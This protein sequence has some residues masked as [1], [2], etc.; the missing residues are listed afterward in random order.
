MFAHFAK[1][2]NFHNLSKIIF[3]STLLMLF[4][5]MNSGLAQNRPPNNTSKK[6]YAIVIGISRYADQGIEPLQFAHRDAALFAEYLES[7]A[8][9]EVPAENIILLQNKKATWSAVYK[10]MD[11]IMERC[12]N[13][14]L[15]YFYFS[16]HGDIENKRVYKNGF[17]I[18]HNTPR[19]N[20]INSS[21]RIEDLNEFA[22]TL[23]LNK[24]AR[25]V[26][27]TDACH[28][29]RL[30]GSSMGGSALIAQQLRTVISNEVRLTSCLPNEVS[31]EDKSW[32]GGR[33]IFSYYLLYG[34]KGLADADKDKK[35]SV[36]DLQ[37]YLQKSI[38]KDPI[39]KSR[40]EKQTPVIRGPARFELSR[41]DSNTLA[42]L[43]KLNNLN[44]DTNNQLIRKPLPPSPSKTFFEF[45]DNYQ[46]NIEK[47][48]PYRTLLALD[49]NQWHRRIFDS[50]YHHLYNQ[51]ASSA[52]PSLDSLK[53]QK[54]QSYEKE[55][56]KNP[57][58]LKRFYNEYLSRLSERGQQVINLYLE[59]DEAAL[60]KMRYYNSVDNQF[61][62][63]TDMLEF[64]FQLSTPKSPM[65]RNLEI[66]KNY[67]YAVACRL[68]MF[69]TA[70]RDSSQQLLLSAQQAIAFAL[71]LE[72]NAAYLHNEAGLIWRLQGNY[73]AAIFHFK[74]A[75]DI[76]PQ[77]FIPWTHLSATY[78]SLNQ[79][80][81]SR[82]SL[83]TA[84]SIQ[85]NFSGV[86][87]QM[88][89][90]AEREK[91][92]L[93]A[94]QNY[95][96]SIK[97]NDRHYF[98]FERLGYI[99]MEYNEFREADSNFYEAEKRKAGFHF[100][101]PQQGE[102]ILPPTHEIPFDMSQ[103]ICML[104]DSILPNDLINLF[105]KGYQEFTFFNLESSIQYFQKC[106]ARDPNF[107]LANHYLG[108]VYLS[109]NLWP[110]AVFYFK[111]S[112]QDYLSGDSFLAYSKKYQKNIV[113]RDSATSDCIY[114]WF[115]RL[116]Y[117]KQNDL[118]FLA[119]AYERWNRFHRAASTYQKLVEINPKDSIP[120]FK[121]WLSYEKLGLWKEAHE[122]ILL[123][124]KHH[125]SKFVVQER[126]AFYRRV[127]S[128]KSS[129]EWAYEAG[130]FHFGLGI[131]EEAQARRS[132]KKPYLEPK[133]EQ[134]WDQLAYRE[135]F[136]VPC[137]AESLWKAPSVRHHAY[138]ALY[139]LR[140]A[141]N[142]TLDGNMEADCY[143]KMADLFERLGAADSAILY[144]RKSL[145]VDTAENVREKLIALQITDHW[146]YDAMLNMDT[147]NMS[148]AMDI[149]DYPT[150]AMFKYKANQAGIAQQLMDTLQ[151]RN[152]A[153]TDQV[154]LIGIQTKLT[155]QQYEEAKKMMLIWIQK[156][157]TD[158]QM[159][160][161]LA[162]VYLKTQ[163]ET[164]AYDLLKQAIAS[165]F[166]YYWVLQND[167]A[168]T[169]DQKQ[170]ANWKKLTEKVK[171]PE[172]KE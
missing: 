49:K 95:H 116:H 115:H 109:K 167:P 45:L 125:D 51:I 146:P 15:V 139:Y 21:L 99:Q 30:A 19:T 155:L 54:I 110:E 71:K 107:P 67:F 5:A 102:S 165:G 170:S 105:L 11:D 84:A 14:D 172:I 57:D 108:R 157:P 50:V 138:R 145:M 101:S 78:W 48:V 129:P 69:K 168:W 130:R 164:E 31:F 58:A 121:L 24:K 166:S 96:H 92:L 53:L 65:Q 72:K 39:L 131:E 68:N 8:G 29:G 40:N 118:Y 93:L 77:W 120:F 38:A 156:H 112:G 82:N 43:K 162:R 46:P 119:Y 13:G 134:L 22:N 144:Y 17:L 124:A 20:Y 81:S 106:L 113:A 66:L 86:L 36:V 25:V 127:D 150:Y 35:V 160:Y 80:D 32:G 37:S 137:T 133:E 73:A 6:T 104:P 148:G 41:V 23:S 79:W 100:F 87:N 33:S 12:S 163:Q 75:T 61:E 98:P 7:K 70:N 123:F 97:Q 10:A 55:L 85:A 128:T 60:E 1:R 152:L 62:V 44:Q 149:E 74:K 88:G 94:E 42:S 26:L 9:G 47:F 159:M 52:T 171:Q 28:S 89:R 142:N 18:C 158:H 91:N 76:S 114:Q 154:V 117:P 90:F 56:N 27:I 59:G 132:K 3:G 153:L 103:G 169:V 111:K 136:V 161:A 147:L 135:P 63:Y 2:W 4:F 126:S 64:A 151:S 34:L 143:H 83:Q 16:G 140:K 122:S 141:S